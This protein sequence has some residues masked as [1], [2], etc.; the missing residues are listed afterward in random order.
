M[1]PPTV[2]RAV[3]TGFEVTT[4]VA[5]AVGVGLLTTFVVAVATA[6]AV[7]LAVGS[8]LGSA[9]TGALAA[10]VAEL[11]GVALV[12]GPSPNAGFAV[13]VSTGWAV[14]GS[15]AVSL[16]VAA[17]GS[18]ALPFCMNTKAPIPPPTSASPSRPITKPAELFFCGGATGRPHS[19]CV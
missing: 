6:V 13:A 15:L 12:P 4:A 1:P 17:A 10:N 9:E 8:A 14:A 2:G 3:A 11:V 5:F 16:A 7:G 18:G 19:V